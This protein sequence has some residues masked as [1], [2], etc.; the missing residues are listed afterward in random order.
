MKKISILL[1]VFLG[2]ILLFTACKNEKQNDNTDDQNQEVSAEQSDNNASA[3]E[4][5]GDTYNLK[6]T[7]SEVKWFATKVG[8]K[9]NG[10][11]KI[12]DG[13]LKLDNGKISGGSFTLDMNSIEVQDLE[14]EWKEKLERHLKG[15]AENKED[16][17]FNVAKFPTARF[18]ITKVANL[19]SREEKGNIMVYGDLTIKGITNP[20]GMRAEF[21]HRDNMLVVGVGELIIDRTLWGVNYNSKKIFPNIQDNIIADEIKLQFIFETEKA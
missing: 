9:H 8:G 13:F 3:S 16:H 19:E 7:N 1:P 2:S 18:D 6:N 14:G 5:P 15:L 17:F 20:V 11:V 21:K 12:Q 4:L 10:I